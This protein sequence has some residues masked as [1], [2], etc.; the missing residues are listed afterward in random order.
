MIM[1][2]FHTARRR[3]A[4]DQLSTAEEFS[5]PHTPIEI[6]RAA[7]LL[8]DY[9]PFIVD[10]AGEE[11]ATVLTRA[12]A[13]REHARTA[14]LQV[15]HVRVAFT[16]QDY[17]SVSPR[18]KA[19]AGL[20]GARLLADGSPEA[21]VHPD[22]GPGGDD[23]VVTKTRFGSFSTTNLATHLHGRGIDT[24]IVAGIS[25]GGV[26]LSTVRDAADRD[27]QLYVLSDCCADP[28][29]EVH[30]VLIEHVFPHQADVIG[31]D[32]FARLL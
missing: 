25:T 28:H 11:G 7:L 5:L 32:D 24:L 3:Y 6:S 9:Q 21:A 16:E 27:Y 23:V 4:H 17:A 1:L 15:V 18:N 12:K 14:G 22:L 13:A 10:S 30:R 19:F 8:M 29:P 31:L 26:V 2:F 20:A